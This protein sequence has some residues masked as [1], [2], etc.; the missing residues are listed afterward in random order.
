MD[1]D[2]R[3]SGNRFDVEFDGR[4][5]YFEVSG[6]DVP[7][8]APRDF[9]VWASL[10]FAMRRGG[11][12]H[13]KGTVDPAVLENARKLARIWSMWLPETYSPVTISA[14]AEAV[15]PPPASDGGVLLYSGGVD[16]T[17]ALV[18]AM[19]GE[20]LAG[21]LTVHGMDYGHRDEAAIAALLEKT[22]PLLDRYTLPRFVVRTDLGRQARQLGLTHAFVLSSCLFLLSSSFGRGHIA[23]DITPE[24]DFL[25]F[26]WGT[27]HIT[28]PLFAG[29]H[30]RLETLSLDVSRIH[31]LDLLRDDPVALKAISFC[32]VKAMRPH[33]CGE[34]AKCMRNKTMFVALSG[35]CPDI[36]L[37]PGVTEARIRKLDVASNVAFKH[38]AEILEVA[39]ERGFLDRLPGL[40]AHVAAGIAARR[41]RAARARIAQKV[42]L[43]ASKYLKF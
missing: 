38:Y 2:V 14:D 28:N 9:A 23:A 33:N 10:P 13:I 20:G 3:Q 21:V 43:Y 32:G 1:V 36:F 40:E 22:Q 37:K 26:P 6:F 19:Q 7:D 11:R 25:A 17:Y 31:K 42:K 24:Q 27:N 16:S 34:C 41:R 15:P 8:P 29:S 18:R 39:R 30:F 35:D 4:S 12:L 5:I